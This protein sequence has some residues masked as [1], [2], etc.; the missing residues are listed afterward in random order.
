MRSPDAPARCPRSRSRESP[1]TDF[2]VSKT[3]PCS[4]SVLSRLV[5]FWGG[6]HHARDRFLTEEFEHFLHFQLL[7]VAGLDDALLLSH[8]ILHHRLQFYD[9]FFVL[10]YS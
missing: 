1:S 4:P 5:Q 8:A 6:A 3:V 9:F 2:R 10:F 7:L